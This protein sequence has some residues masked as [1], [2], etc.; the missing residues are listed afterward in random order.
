MPVE[1][2]AFQQPMKTCKESEK[3]ACEDLHTSRKKKNRLK[4]NKKIALSEES[5]MAISDLLAKFPWF[6][7]D[8][9]R[10]VEKLNK[11]KAEREVHTSTRDTSNGIPHVDVFYFFL[12]ISNDFHRNFTVFC[13]D[14]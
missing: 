4:A 11:V 3:V 1:G 10:A 9:Q 7:E 12:M 14:S 5:K 2:R 13:F 6:Q 8:F